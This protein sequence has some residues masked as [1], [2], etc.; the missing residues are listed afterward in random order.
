M[1]SPSRGSRRPPWWPETEPWPPTGPP[2]WA[3][4][5]RRGRF[6]W[7]VGSLLALL[8]VLAAS[9][10]ALVFW[11]V[12]GAV[13]MIDAP[14]GWF[15]WA[16]FRGFAFIGGVVVIFLIIRAF[17]GAA[18]P[19]ADLIEAA[20]QVAEGDYSARVPERGPRE[21]REL[22]HAFNSMSARLQASD[23]Q[24]R[25]LIA[26]VTHEL[27][28]P[29]TV[30]QGN[31]EGL[32]DGVY[33]ADEAHLMPVLE[34]TRV[35]A[36]LID[37]LRTL[38]L[39]ESGALKLQK[40]TTDLGTLASET[41]ASFRAQADAAGIS[42]EAEAAAGVPVIRADPARIREVLDNLI[43]NALRHTPRGGAIRVCT[44]AAPAGERDGRVMLSVSDT[45]SGITVDD[46]PH[47]FERFY[48]ARDSRGMGLGLAIAKDLIEA[49]GGE[50][51]A[52]ST[53][54]EGTT[55][56]CWLPSPSP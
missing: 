10:A 13:G 33:P 47:I 20:R 16:P 21:V 49:H 39:A 43:S 3:W 50:I 18:T 30:I 31:L 4:H 41:V 55:I 28:T 44:S 23:E 54:G 29:L 12:A 56:E 42:L 14:R 35:L 22:A 9:A 37:D 24:R 1:T 8:L 36:R 25:G 52:R 5:A 45:G 7:R 48:R 2:P 11:L 32:I 17:R 34:E 19:V 26:D 40:E 46:L 51:V 15:F 6:F 53:L 38:S 27:R